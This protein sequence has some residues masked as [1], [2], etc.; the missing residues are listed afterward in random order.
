MNVAC[1][2]PTFIS[3][4]QFLNGGFVKDNSTF[5]RATVKDEWRCVSA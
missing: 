4:E 3:I 2:W 5:V 1:A